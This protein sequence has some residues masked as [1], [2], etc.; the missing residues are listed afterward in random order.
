MPWP[1]WPVCSSVAHVDRVASVASRRQCGV[2]W[3]QVW[4][5]GNEY[6]GLYD[7]CALGGLLCIWPVYGLYMACIWPACGL[8]EMSTVAH[9]VCVAR[10]SCVSR[11]SWVPHV[12]YVAP[13]AWRGPCGLCVPCGLYCPSGLCVP[14]GLCGP[15]GLCV[16][17]GLMKTNAVTA[18]VISESI[19]MQDHV[20]F[21]DDNVDK[22]RQ[23][24]CLRIAT[25]DAATIS[26]CR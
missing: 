16:P 17:R 15:C 24:T 22:Q 25:R 23:M 20:R 12:V 9:G 2:L 6:R 8:M 5:D 18:V 26:I 7:L 3:D 19:A 21:H 10:V 11:V 14:C 13:V 1:V 4:F